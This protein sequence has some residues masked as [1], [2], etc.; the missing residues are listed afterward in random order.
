MRRTQ[1]DERIHFS[2]TNEDIIED[3]EDRERDQQRRQLKQSA[4]FNDSSNN[5]LSGAK[6]SLSPADVVKGDK[7]DV[8]SA[9][10][11]RKSLHEFLMNFSIKDK[12]SASEVASSGD[13]NEEASLDEDK[14]YNEI[15][16]Q[17]RKG[18]DS[19]NN[20][21]SSGRWNDSSEKLELLFENSELKTA[22]SLAAAS[23]LYFQ[24]KSTS[25]TLSNRQLND[26]LALLH[27]EAASEAASSSDVEDDVDSAAPVSQQESI[28]GHQY[29]Y[30]SPLPRRKQV[31]LDMILDFV[32]RETESIESSPN[33]RQSRPPRR[34]VSR[35]TATNTKPGDLRLPL[36]TERQPRARFHD[37]VHV[38]EYAVTVGD[39]PSCGGPCPIQL[40]WKY[41]QYT[42]SLPL[43]NGRVGPGDRETLTKLTRQPSDELDCWFADISK[44]I[45]H[46]AN[47]SVR[48][49]P[50]RRRRRV[51]C[52]TEKQR[53]ERIAAV[54][55]WTMQQV[56]QME[57]LICESEN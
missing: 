37:S 50:R 55:G 40:D 16:S 14:L 18:A 51:R 7:D 31:D 28:E 42:M 4:M 54:Q 1:D 3:V 36:E 34:P 38:R 32:K 17:P 8:C 53:R 41:D 26:S 49:R 39:N 56:G 9:E 10:E 29:K 43:S 15:L 48:S 2:P 11:T 12:G 5:S 45:D 33:P 44:S 21:S 22:T 30:P 6:L 57:D 13:G 35:P 24:N 19:N 25:G 27:Y 23:K 20:A 46:A 47:G 52:L